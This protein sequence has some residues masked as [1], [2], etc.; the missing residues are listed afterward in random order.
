[1]ARK[2]TS[3][4]KDDPIA[5]ELEAGIRGTDVYQGS[6]YALGNVPGFE[7]MK[8]ATP[9]Y[10]KYADLYNLYLG[11]GFDAAQDDF[12][13]PPGPAAP[14]GGGGGG[15][16][17]GTTTGGTGGVNTPEEQRLIDAGIG[18]QTGPGQP[19]FAPGEEPVTQAD[20]DAF[21]QI[22]VSTDYTDAYTSLG[23][24]APRA[25]YAEQLQQLQDEQAANAREQASVAQYDTP[26][27]YDTRK[28]AE[29]E[30]AGAGIDDMYA[31]DWQGG[32]PQTIKTTSMDPTGMIPQIS[33]QLVSEQDTSGSLYQ[34]AKD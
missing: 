21:N 1:M 25:T 8:Y 18:L 12:V 20:I 31:T 24:E 5:E 23:E 16:G 2:F 15:A 3:L 7:G 29:L 10:N 30:R 26:T 32:E 4:Y 22:P 11:G 27:Y 28:Q 33:D 19:V 13:T 14:I 17:T 34:K 6:P 9:D